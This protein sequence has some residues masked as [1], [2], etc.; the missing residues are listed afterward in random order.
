MS[1]NYP[2][3]LDVLTNPSATDP[4]TN[5]SHA[6]QHANANDAIEALEAKVGIDGSATTT[7][8]DYKLSG[9]IGS[10]KATSLTGAETLTNKTLTTPVVASLY[11]DAGKTKLM[12][13]PNTASDTLTSNAA[14]QTL[15]NKT[16]T[17]TTNNV[18][19]KSLH[20]ATTV[21]DVSASAAP[22]NGQVL[23]AT[24]STT[25]TWQNTS[26]GAFSGASVTTAGGTITTNTTISVAWNGETFDTDSYHD[27]STNNER[28][29][30]PSTGYYLVV[31]NIAHTSSVSSLITT[32]QLRTNGSAIVA[33][34]GYA[35]SNAISTGGHS[36]SAIV[37]LTSSQYVEARLSAQASGLTYTYSATGSFF[38]ITKLGA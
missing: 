10:D 3:S 23:T 9:V 11:Q 14:T 17:S 5:P 22:T 26:A 25:A 1:T 4:V 19:A 33:S 37:Y 27:N 13:V 21:V 20:S 34:S 30:V 36:V 31:C 18:A 7:T 8:H 12:T 28:L 16:I 6:T 24:G 29:T 38:T 15:T 35:A 2:T 32:L